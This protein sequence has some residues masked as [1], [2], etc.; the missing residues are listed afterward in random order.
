MKRE[1]S[2]VCLVMGCFVPLWTSVG[3]HPSSIRQENV[4]GDMASVVETR[5]AVNTR[6][7]NG[8][9]DLE[10]RPYLCAFLDDASGSTTEAESAIS[11]RASV[12]PTVRT[13]IVYVPAGT[14][15]LVRLVDRV[16]SRDEPGT[17]FA[18]TLDTDLF[19][20]GKVVARAGA[21]VY[22]RVEEAREAWR[23]FGR[24][25]VS[26]SLTE[27]S[28][29]GVM[30]SIETYELAKTGGEAGKKTLGLSAAGAA[31]GAVVDGGEG[32]AKGAGIGALTSLLIRAETAVIPAGSLLEFQ[33][34]HA[35]AV[36]GS[37]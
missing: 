18:A 11:T 25:S 24:S 6:K 8:H 17:R 28:F 35:V 1:L 2:V 13:H 9:S 27:I 16:T 19:A 14:V 30:K 4:W 29:D 34:V 15:L 23:V 37:R 12:L 33:L 32:A 7:G 36:R 5:R 26:I 20:E 3:A 21:R 31:I 10:T 22:G